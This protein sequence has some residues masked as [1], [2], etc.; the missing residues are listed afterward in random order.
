M[1]EKPEH[2]CTPDC[3]DPCPLAGVRREPIPIESKKGKK[4]QP[5]KLFAEP[6]PALLTSA[7]LRTT[8]DGNK[9]A[10]LKFLINLHDFELRHLLP[11]VVQDAYHMMLDEKE[12]TGMGL[13]LEVEDRTASLG[14][15]PTGKSKV[16]RTGCRLFDFALE[17]KQPKDS[18]ERLNL[19]FTLE[20]NDADGVFGR[21]LLDEALSQTVIIAL[22]E[23]QPELP[24]AEPE[25]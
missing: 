2:Y 21:W 9:Q 10:R 3:P 16:K 25:Q 1:P 15:Y 7:F 13:N 17:R 5:K 19:V 20:L 22:Q 18:Q 23:T 4:Q 6:A 11:Q 12:I 24:G 8:G 14:P